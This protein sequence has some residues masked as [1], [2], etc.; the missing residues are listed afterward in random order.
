MTGSSVLRS[1]QR[2]LLVT[3]IAAFIAGVFFRFWDLGGAPLAVDEYFLGTSTLN[4]AERGLPEFACGGYY[5][6]GLLLQYLSLPLLWLGNSLEFTVR[7]WPAVASVLT[8]AAAWRIAQLAG[9]RT[10][11]ALTVVLVSLSLWEVEFGRFGRMYAPFQTIFVW[12]VYFQI[13]HLVEGRQ[14][15]R[16]WYLGLS[17]VAIPTFEGSALLL[18]LNFL[19]IVYPGRHWSVAHLV[20]ATGLFLIRLVAQE[21][22]F[23]RLGTVSLDVSPAAETVSTSAALSLPVD[24]P[25]IPDPGWPVVVLGL[26]FLGGLLWRIRPAVRH[27]AIVFWTATALAFAFGMVALGV[28]LL[29]A[30]YLLRSPAPTGAPLPKPGTITAWIVGAAIT[31]LGVLSAS[32]WLGGATSESSVKQALMHV[33]NYPDIYHSVVQPWLLTIPITTVALSLLSLPALTFALRATPMDA[34]RSACIRYLFA[35]VIL[36]VLLVAALR[37]PHAITRYTYFLYPLLLV[38]AATGMAI[39]AER[40]VATDA[41][42]LGSILIPIVTVFAVAEDFRLTHLLNINETEFRFRTA[43]ER[44]LQVHYYPRWDF[45]AAAEYVNA[46]LATDDR[47]IVFDQP[48]PHYLDRTSGLFIRYGTS[49]YR[50]I[51]GC[52]GTRDLWSNARLLDTEQDVEQLIATTSGNVWLVMRSAKYSWRDPLEID[53]AETYGN[54]PAFISQDGHLA[55]YRASEPSL[56][57]ERTPSTS[58]VRAGNFRRSLRRDTHVAGRLCG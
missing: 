6:R 40:L 7:F 42:R 27:P 16:W 5:T 17:A 37:Q 25:V 28:A 19:P 44:R 2:L 38:L 30:G 50:L 3:A 12:Y 10:A 15:A 21:I 18:A 35:V 11:A 26:I 55:V 9:G 31:W 14:S 20:V 34:N 24:L 29:A 47:V 45:R 49:L 52:D 1:E 48:L 8:I 36:L 41:A 53:L 32:L 58:R 22:D 51:W 56:H 39:A 33:A 57:S 43:Y 46:R 23:R 4:T 54:R 13:R